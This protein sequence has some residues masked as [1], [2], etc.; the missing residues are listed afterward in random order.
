MRWH[1]RRPAEPALPTALHRSISVGELRAALA[2]YT[3]EA[4][5]RLSVPVGRCADGGYAGT[6]LYSID[7]VGEAW[8]YEGTAQVFEPVLEVRRP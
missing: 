8:H 7:A 3:D 4:E 1:R 6:A 5:V 2:A